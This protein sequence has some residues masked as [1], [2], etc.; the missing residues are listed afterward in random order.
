MISGEESPRIFTPEYYDRLRQLESS[1]WWNAGMRDIADILLARASLN[2]SGLVLDAGCGSGQSMQWFLRERPGW[3]AVGADVA[4]E[5]LDSAHAAG[6]IVSLASVLELPF[7]GGSVD[8][9]LTLDVLQHLPL[10][11]GDSRALAEF[12]RVLRPGGVLLARTN[13]QAFPRTA[14]DPAASF[15]K[16]ELR[17]LREKLRAAGFEVIQ[18]G[19]VNAFPGLAE[20][21]RELRARYGRV[22]GYHGL[23]SQPRTE[24]SL[25]HAAKRAWLRVEGRALAGGWGLPWGRT[26]FA[27]CSKR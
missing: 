14:D 5:G 15:R 4:R 21:P 22:S 12:A 16:Y 27:L 9:I 23:L 24:N 10:D 8:C 17:S 2:P 25:M 1:S 20:I 26:I 7:A 3:S 11:G 18:S 19:R 13:S 6:Y